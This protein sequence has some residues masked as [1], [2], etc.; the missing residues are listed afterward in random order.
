[1]NDELEGLF[2]S[3]SLEHCE[4]TAGY[5]LFITESAIYPF[6]KFEEQLA[7][8]NDYCFYLLTCLKGKVTEFEAFDIDSE[9]W[10]AHLATSES[11]KYRKFLSWR[12]LYRD[13]NKCTLLSLLLA[14][15]ESSLNEIAAWFSELSGYSSQ[16]KKVRNPKVSDYLQQI[17]SCCK[18]DLPCE[19]AEELAYYHSVRKIRNQFVHNEWEQITDRYKRFIL[20]DVIDMISHVITKVEK[21]ALISGLIG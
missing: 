12:F 6:V 15:F 20:A 9:N 8:I 3:D 13:I 5:L 1:M 10:A 16:W 21:S 11:W 4:G 17:G 2:E 19:M 14:F 18:V 7:E